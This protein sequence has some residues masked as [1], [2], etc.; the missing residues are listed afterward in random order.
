MAEITLDTKSPKHLITGILFI[1][2]A[3]GG[4]SLMGLTIEPEDT[5]EL[6]IHSAKLEEKIKTLDDTQE[7]LKACRSTLA[8]LAKPQKG[9]RQQKQ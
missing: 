5:T 9:K 1:M 7:K 8:D 2:G 3:V 6:R 4:G